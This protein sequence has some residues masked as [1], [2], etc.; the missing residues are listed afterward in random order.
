MLCYKRQGNYVVCNELPSSI[1]SW[2]IVRGAVSLGVRIR[3]VVFFSP[4]SK[5]L[6]LVSFLSVRLR[7][8]VRVRIRV[9]VRF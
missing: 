8:R 3:K 7:F 1:V 9:R 4:F 5:F 6:S 2:V